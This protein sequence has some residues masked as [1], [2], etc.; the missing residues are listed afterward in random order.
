MGATA[1]PPFDNPDADIILRS[2]DQPHPTDF[3][4][5]KFLLSLASPFFA[6]AFTLPQPLVDSSEDVP[7][8]EMEENA[9]TLRT[10]LGFCYPISVHPLP[11]LTTPEDVRAIFQAAEKFEMK[12][13]QNHIRE[14]LVDEF[15]E[16]KP[17]SVFA[18]ACHYGWKEVVDQAAYR[19]LAL[20]ILVDS[21][22]ADESSLD[23]ISAA[24]YTRLLRYRK[25][26]GEAAKSEV[27]RLAEV[28]AT[29]TAPWGEKPTTSHVCLKKSGCDGV[30]NWW[31]LWMLRS[32]EAFMDIPGRSKIDLEAPS[33][34]CRD[35]KRYLMP[36][37]R[38]YEAVM[39][40][41]IRKKISA[42]KINVLQQ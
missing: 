19:F 11:R 37:V 25:E 8:M 30:G 34:I 9:K 16:D 31:A 17:V 36:K 7:V 13:I 39:L 4:V 28:G 5:F 6:A 21:P 32:A 33:P 3:R 29:S 15:L 35:C 23:L 40:G 14:A 38:K 10:I 1:K 24:T 12:G 42:V 20:P 41:C 18:I 27:I 26:C 2:S 22:P